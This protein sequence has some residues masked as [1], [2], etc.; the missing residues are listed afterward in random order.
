MHKLKIHTIDVL[1]SVIYSR[2]LSTKYFERLLRTNFL[3][4]SHLEDGIRTQP[5]G[6]SPN[7]TAVI[8][9]K[10]HKTELSRLAHQQRDPIGIDLHN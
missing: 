4:E 5:D 1:F 9:F 2:L 6:Y 3:L 7:T 10:L 8:C